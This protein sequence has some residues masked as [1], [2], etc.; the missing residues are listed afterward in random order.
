MGSI[1]YFGQNS[2]WEEG[3]IPICQQWN[4]NCM[5]E[6][7]DWMLSWV[8]HVRNFQLQLGFWL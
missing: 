6:F 5:L 3:E 2:L 4:L 8:I 7:N 1:N